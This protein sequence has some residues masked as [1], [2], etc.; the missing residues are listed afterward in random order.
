M[1]KIGWTH[2]D[3]EDDD[4]PDLPTDQDFLS[5]VDRAH[6]VYRPSR[7]VSISGRTVTHAD[8][9]GKLKLSK[10]HHAGRHIIAS[11][12]PL[13]VIVASMTERFSDDG[14]DGEDDL[15]AQS[16]DHHVVD[17][18]DFHAQTVTQLSEG[19]WIVHFAWASDGTL[20]LETA[21]AT[22]RYPPGQLDGITDVP[23]GV[24]FGTPPFPEV[25]GT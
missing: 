9:P 14:A 10:G 1:T 3:V 25:G 17:L 2:D 19:P 6:A 8:A 13:V 20:L 5:I 16:R 11:P 12:D 24:H 4:P 22:R 7:S 18:V 21:E 15:D 23:E